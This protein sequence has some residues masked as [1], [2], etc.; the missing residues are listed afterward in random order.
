MNNKLESFSKSKS[1]VGFILMTAVIYFSLL[2]PSYCFACTD[3]FTRQAHELEDSRDRTEWMLSLSAPLFSENVLSK[4][5]NEGGGE[6]R[7][8]DA[9]FDDVLISNDQIVTTIVT[10]EIDTGADSGQD[11]GLGISCGDC[12]ITDRLSED[13]QLQ[14]GDALYIRGD[15]YI[16][17][18]IDSSAAKER[19][20]QITYNDMRNEYGNYYI[21]QTIGGS[22]DALNRLSSALSQEL[23]DLKIISLQESENRNSE[24]NAFLK[25]MIQSRILVMSVALI[26]GVINIMILVMSHMRKKI[27]QIGVH[28]AYGAFFSDVIWIVI[29]DYVGEFLFAVILLVL[30]FKQILILAGLENETVIDVGG[31]IAISLF[32]AILLAIT[33]I[34]AA[35]KLYSE[36]A[37]DLLEERV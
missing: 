16:I 21:Q 3:N 9:R 22:K 4:Y 33:S 1:P 13:T 6:I 11:A 34:I 27:H 25:E 8:I 5:I 23:P 36:N 31:C 29:C 17:K 14:V 10:G 15:K 2:I 28:V 24:T 7:Y 30:T 18:R 35:L 26:I 12:V 19:S 37:A 20:V 32:G